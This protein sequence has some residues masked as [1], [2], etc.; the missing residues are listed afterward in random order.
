MNRTKKM[1]YYSHEP[2]C[3]EEIL[4]LDTKLW[5]LKTTHF[6]FLFSLNILKG[7]QNCMG[8]IKSP[9]QRQKINIKTEIMIGLHR[10]VQNIFPSIPKGLYQAIL[11]L[12]E[13]CS[14]FLQ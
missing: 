1:Q 10:V 4:N 2:H 6:Y 3:K 14:S 5:S 13:D 8:E 12:S 9:T 11:F 7:E